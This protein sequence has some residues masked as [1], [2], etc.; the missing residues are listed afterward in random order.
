VLGDDAAET[1]A[2]VTIAFGGAEPITFLISRVVMSSMALSC[3]F[4]GPEGSVGLEKLALWTV[5]PGR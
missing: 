1:A 2:L 4:C 5:A 3:S